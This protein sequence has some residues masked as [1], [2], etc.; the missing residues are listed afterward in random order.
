MQPVKQGRTIVRPCLQ[1]G[2]AMQHDS[3]CQLNLV[4]NATLLSA[5]NTAHA[6]HNGT[7]VHPS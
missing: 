2:G 5:G 1:K 4:Q 7:G 3:V 6:V